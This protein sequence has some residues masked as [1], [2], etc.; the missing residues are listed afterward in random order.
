MKVKL[1]RLSI[2]DCGYPVLMEN[3][4][5]GTE[6]EIDPNKRYH[7]VLKCG[8]CGKANENIGVWADGRGDQRGGFLPEVLF[9]VAN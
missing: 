4:P 2:C 7:F 5:L 3:I 1:Q 9:Q 8:G 6:Y